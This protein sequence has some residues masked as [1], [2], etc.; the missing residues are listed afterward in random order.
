MRYAQSDGIFLQAKQ[1]FTHVV[2]LPLPPLPPTAQTVESTP[3]PQPQSANIP[4]APLRH[5]HQ[6]LRPSHGS[7]RLPRA[8]P[9]VLQGHGGRDGG[10]VF[11]AAGAA[12]D[13]GV[14]AAG[15][16]QGAGEPPRRRVRSRQGD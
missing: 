7:S 1:L 2:P 12:R 14:R 4:S 16:S 8:M 3:A 13:D 6:V 15:A 10:R 9:G 11:S 5:S